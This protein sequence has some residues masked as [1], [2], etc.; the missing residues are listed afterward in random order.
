[1]QHSLRLQ[2]SC[3]LSIVSFIFTKHIMN[4]QE[5]HDHIRRVK[6][7]YF[8][9][10]IYNSQHRVHNQSRSQEYRQKAWIS[11]VG[12]WMSSSL[13]H[14][15]DLVKTSHLHEHLPWNLAIKVNISCIHPSSFGNKARDKYFYFHLPLPAQI[16]K[17]YA[18]QSLLD[19]SIS[20]NH[21]SISNHLSL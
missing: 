8:K 9:K 3:L 4:P 15:S 10:N 20:L 16:W 13:R 18:L 7:V 6:Y 12:N 11:H 1:M 5:V 2:L 14:M 19:S 21:I 17:P